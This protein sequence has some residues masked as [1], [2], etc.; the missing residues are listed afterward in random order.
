M[1][2]RL[3]NVKNIPSD[4]L[5]RFNNKSFSNGE[6]LKLSEVQSAPDFYYEFELGKNYTFVI[7]DPDA[8]IGFWIH[9]CIYNLSSN[10]IGNIFY[11]YNPPSPPVRTGPKKDGRHRYYCILYE[12]EGKIRDNLVEKER[13]FKEYKDFRDLLGVLLKPVIY[14]Y[15][16]CKN[17]LI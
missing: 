7:V 5:V 16:V 6:L 1:S 3:N 11:D 4:L 8:P 10:S 17:G 12:Q 2:N 14:R 13:G 15:F 9:E